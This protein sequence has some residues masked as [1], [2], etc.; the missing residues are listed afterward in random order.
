MEFDVIGEARS[1]LVALV[2]VGYYAE[3]DRKTRET[4][5]ALG[6]DDAPT[7]IDSGFA[8][9][10]LPV[11][12]SDPTPKQLSGQ[13]YVALGGLAFV[14]GLV[15]M[16]LALDD[17]GPLAGYLMTFFSLSFLVAP[18]LVIY[19]LFRLITGN[20]K[21][22]SAILSGLFGLWVQTKVKSLMDDKSKGR[23]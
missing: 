16:F 1:S 23:R 20:R 2:F 15:G 17:R 8:E 19:P 13:A 6:Y 10:R 3:M 11:G 7:G 9:S 22:L 21:M 18:A 4:R 12:V 5:R 14:L